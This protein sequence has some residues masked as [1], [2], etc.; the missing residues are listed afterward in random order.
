MTQ[1]GAHKLF[2]NVTIGAGG[3]AT[4]AAVYMG[5]AQTMALHLQSITGTGPDVSFT[6]QVSTNK[7]S[8]FITPSSPVT[9]GV[10]QAAANVLDFAPEAAKFIKIIATNNNGAQ[11]VTLTAVLAM[12]ED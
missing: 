2:D 1:M 4:S 7:D 6:Y 8:D 9:I 5:Q 11:T 10:N 3:S 12:Q